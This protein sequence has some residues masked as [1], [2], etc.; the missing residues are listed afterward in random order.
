MTENNGTFVFYILEWRLTDSGHSKNPPNSDNNP[1]RTSGIT[2]KPVKTRQSNKNLYSSKCGNPI[3]EWNIRTSAGL[4]SFL[5]FFK[6]SKLI[7]YCTPRILKF[8]LDWQTIHQI[9]FAPE[10]IKKIGL[11]EAMIQP[12]KLSVKWRSMIRLMVDFWFNIVVMK[13]SFFNE[14]R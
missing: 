1:D 7:K 11:R 14:R 2:A 9:Q 10:W 13:G 4:T 8:S 5:I 6:Y 3:N 12:Q